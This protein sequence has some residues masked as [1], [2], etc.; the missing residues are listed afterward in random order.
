MLVQIITGTTREGRF[1]EV[2]AEW[3]SG[4]LQNRTEFAR[5]K[6]DARDHPRTFDAGE[7]RERPVG[8]AS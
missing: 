5:E 4:E 6:V 3:V 7:R 1:G 2:V 8:V